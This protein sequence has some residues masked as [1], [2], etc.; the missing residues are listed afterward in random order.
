MKLGTRA[1]H[2]ARENAALGAEGESAHTA[3]LYL[4]SNFSYPSATSADRAAEGLGYLYSRHGNPTTAALAR[5][6]AGLEGAEAG[7]TFAS[8][9]AAISSAVLALGAGGV[10]LA[11]EGLYGG[12][13]QLLRD[14]GPQHGLQTRFVPAW[15]V[16]AVRRAIGSETRVLLVETMSNPLL[17][18]ADVRALGGLAKQHGIA[19]IVDG[20]FTTPCLSLP[21][22]EG[23]SIVVHSVSKYIGGHGDLVGG[24]A[25]G[26]SEVMAR[27]EP[28]ARL[29]GGVMDP[30]SAWLCLRGIRTLP[31]RMERQCANAAR[32]A[33]VLATLPEVLRIHYPG[34]A[35]HADHAVARAAL[36]APGAMISFE[37]ADGDAA[38]RCYDRVAVVSRAASLGE[39]TSLLTHPVSFSHRGVPAAERQ[40]LGIV[41]GLLRLSVGI[42]DVE[43]LEADLRQAL[44]AGP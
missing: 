5:A 13:I 43:D 20:T 34:R 14:I 26:S 16:D 1:V 4:T 3:P 39:V 37:L 30:F 27:L 29:L 32:L 8:G 7:M 24:V 17:R 21:L 15:D 11:S 25:V 35:D 31:L 2:V 38:R 9:M 10:V 40:R 28:Y 42:E 33:D 41:D 36:S 44:A 18:V 23:A 22:S 12:S 6:V 19:L